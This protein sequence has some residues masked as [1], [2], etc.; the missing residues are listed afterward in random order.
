MKLS[1]EEQIKELYLKGVPYLEISQQLNIHKR[2]IYTVVNNIVEEQYNI[3]K[4][5]RED[6]ILTATLMERNIFK[7]INQGKN[8]DKYITPFCTY[9]A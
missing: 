8:I 1:I 3:L 9:C 5:N 2:K 7:L 6:R 4:T